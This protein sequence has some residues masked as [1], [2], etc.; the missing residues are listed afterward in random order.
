MKANLS[1]AKNRS[2]DPTTGLRRNLRKRAV[3]T[4]R[5]GRYRTEVAIATTPEKSMTAAGGRRGSLHRGRSRQQLKSNLATSPQ[6]NHRHQPAGRSPD[7]SDHDWSSIRARSPAC[8]R[9]E[10]CSARSPSKLASSRR[11]VSRIAQSPMP[12]CG[13]I[14]GSN[15]HSL[16]SQQRPYWRASVSRYREKSAQA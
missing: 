2:P 6:L 12:A 14:S 5:V 10:N 4:R 8:D 13:L 9:S 15:S 3:S 7:R 16:A 11:A 1:H